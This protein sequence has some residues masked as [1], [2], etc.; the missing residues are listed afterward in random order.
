MMKD[1]PVIR[2]R[3]NVEIDLDDFV[4]MRYLALQINLRCLTTYM[5]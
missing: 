5:A 2:V 3:F 4:L 1:T